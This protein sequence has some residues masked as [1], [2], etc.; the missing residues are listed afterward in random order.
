MSISEN[1][2]GHNITASALQLLDSG[3][4]QGRF[5]VTD[6]TAV[7]DLTITPR[8]IKR[9]FSTEQEAES[10]ALVSAKKWIDGGKPAI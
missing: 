10:E 4:W 6:L 7:S 3:Q 1:Y 5:V 2:N 8:T 9:T